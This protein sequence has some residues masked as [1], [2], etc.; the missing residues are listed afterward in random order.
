[1]KVVIMTILQLFNRHPLKVK[2]W[3][4]SAGVDFRK[5][6][7]RNVR[8]GGNLLSIGQWRIRGRSMGG[9]YA[10]TNVDWKLWLE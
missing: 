7:A 6:R 10:V 5:F 3:T 9:R 2:R 1:M 8:G 4:S